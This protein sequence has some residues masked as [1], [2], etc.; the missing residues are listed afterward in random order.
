LC[1]FHLRHRH[2]HHC[3]RCHL[4]RRHLHTAPALGCIRLGSPLGSL[5]SPFS[6]HLCSPLC[7][8]L[9]SARKARPQCRGAHFRPSS[10]WK[11]RV[12]PLLS[13]HRITLQAPL[14][15][16][17]SRTPSRCLPRLATAPTRPTHRS[18]PQRQAR[19][20]RPLGV[21]TEPW[22]AHHRPFYHAQKTGQT[23]N[24]DAGRR[25][26]SM[27]RSLSRVVRMHR[28]SHAREA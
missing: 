26:W 17:T 10:I 7:S 11:A 23:P 4:P 12:L 24:G 3:L 15:S 16:W 14:P 27:H 22:Q 28:A 9:C 1:Y 2:P 8:P 20:L 13:L 25:R 21:S 18:L 19:A 6:S 5:D